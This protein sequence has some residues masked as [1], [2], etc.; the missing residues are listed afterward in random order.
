MVEKKPIGHEITGVQLIWWVATY[1]RRRWS[2]KEEK[3]RRCL[4]RTKCHRWRIR[5]RLGNTFQGTKPIISTNRSPRRKSEK[6][7]SNTTDEY[8]TII[9]TLL[10]L[11]VPVL[12]MNTPR[13]HTPIAKGTANLGKFGS[14]MGMWCDVL[15]VGTVVDWSNECP[16]FSCCWTIFGLLPSAYCVN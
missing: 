16:E 1:R 6:E 2:T 10:V 12:T 9:R 5:R 14:A 4:S 15:L 11:Y 7:R 3:T 13:T 8:I